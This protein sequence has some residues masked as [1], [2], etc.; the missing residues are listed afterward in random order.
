MSSSTASAPPMARTPTTPA[1][2]GSPT[3]EPAAGATVGLQSPDAIL[4]ALRIGDLT[5]IVYVEKQ[6]G[7]GPH[8]PV[9]TTSQTC[10]NTPSWALTNRDTGKPRKANND[11]IT[12][13][14]ATTTDGINFA[15]LGAANGL[16]DPYSIALN[17]IRWLG[18][19]S[20]IPL[21][22]GHYGMFLGAG[23]SPDNDS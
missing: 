3:L 10:P 6:L 20:I 2:R 4:G 11:I 19:G 9:L 5:T 16:Q 21:S 13:R 12:I 15:D 23:N 14:V 8:T 17:A 1:T 22:N 18:S 7:G